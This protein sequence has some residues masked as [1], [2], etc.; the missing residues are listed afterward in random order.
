MGR[1]AASAE[2][3]PAGRVSLVVRSQ[4]GGRAHLKPRSGA[5]GV[6]QL[7]E[8]AVALAQDQDVAVAGGGVGIVGA[9]A[10]DVR[11][12]RDRHRTGVALVG[13]VVA[14]GA[15]SDRHQRLIGWY[16]GI[17]DTV[18]LLGG[19]QVQMDGVVRRHLRQQ[20]G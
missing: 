19:S 17:G 20:R 3:Q 12:E 18:V 16:D 15:E 13:V 5:N 6:V 9:A 10:F 1:P 7:E 2:V 4:V 11:V 14:T 8:P